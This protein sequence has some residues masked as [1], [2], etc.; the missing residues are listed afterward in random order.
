MVASSLSNRKKAQETLQDVQ[1]ARTLAATGTKRQIAALLDPHAGVVPFTGREH[2]RARLIAWCQDDQAGHVRLVT[3]GGGVGKTRLALWLERE[4]TRSGWSCVWVGDGRETGAV[5]AIRGITQGRVLLIV[6][7]A[8]TRLGLKEML[9]ATA[10]DKGRALQVLLLARQVGDWWQRLEAGD[11][12]VRTMVVDANQFREEL[13]QEIDADVTH[14]EVVLQAVRYFANKLELEPPASDLVTLTGDDSAA[15]VL[16]LHA[17]ALIS[18]L[19][20]NQHPKGTVVRVDLATVLK[21]LLS[22]EKHYWL[23]RAEQLDLLEGPQGL[24]I[25]QLAQTVAAGCLLG[26]A[27]DSDVMELLRRVPHIAPS[28][29]LAKWLHELYP[30]DDSREWL[31][32]LRPDRLAELHVTD[33]LERSPELADA[34]LNNLNERQ[35][36]RAL[37]LLAQASAEHSGA[38]QLLKT[39]LFR[40]SDV[41]SGI[42]AS[43]DTMIAIANAMPYASP[44]LGPARAAIINRILATLPQGTAQRAG[45]LDDQTR[46]LSSLGWWEDAL[47]TNRE[48]ADIYRGLAPARSAI[49]DYLSKS[50]P[51]PPAFWSELAF[52]LSNQSRIL[53]KLG[54]QEEALSPVEEAVHIYEQMVG[55]YPARFQSELVI[56]LNIR[57]DILDS[58]GR[59]SEAE[60]ARYESYEILERRDAY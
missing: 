39:S 23:G 13:A 22:H 18:V 47:A 32:S 41:I 14:R 29:K 20:A 6:D 16:D 60:E 8:E 4:L 17:A 26:A 53:L 30:P 45:W 40:F 19:V 59:T 1:D 43:R 55:L 25:D 56:S 5:G 7:Y 3:G 33:Q 34:C 38:A 27:D 11:P 36:R 37:I 2:E 51:T 12:V 42:D 49:L 52:V 10:T 28:A 54:R 24:T 50:S 35:A 9:R 57:A 15:R 44:V 31:G 46:L 48:A 58:L 21:E